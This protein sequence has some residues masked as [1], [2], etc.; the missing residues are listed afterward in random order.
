DDAKPANRAEQ[1]QP[2][3]LPKPQVHLQG[4]DGTSWSANGQVDAAG[5]FTLEKVLPGRYRVVSTG[6]LGYIKSMRLGR[7]E[8]TGDI[9]DLSHGTVEVALTILVSTEFGSAS[10]SVQS[11]AATTAGLRVLL[12]PDSQTL[13]GEGPF[14]LGTIGA[15]GSYSFD[16]VVPGNYKLVAVAE[17]DVD[18]ILQGGDECDTYAPVTETVTIRAGEKVVQDLKTLKRE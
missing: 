4:I 11:D 17:D 10:G 18:E 12:L 7:A 8:I 13:G 2:N 3:P 16:S 15:D 6:G 1:T 5:A 9:I 14:K